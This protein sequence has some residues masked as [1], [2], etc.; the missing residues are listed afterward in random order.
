MQNLITFTDN[1]MTDMNQ[2]TTSNDF[3]GKPDSLV[4]FREDMPDTL[5]LW[6]EAYFRIEVTTSERSQQEQK[7]RQLTIV[8]NH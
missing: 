3:A 5:G 7:A 4:V 1:R 8:L 2:I 6:A